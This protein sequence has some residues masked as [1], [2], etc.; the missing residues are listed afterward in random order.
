MARPIRGESSKWEM[1]THKCCTYFKGRI[2][3]INDNDYEGV[4][5]CPF[6]TPSDSWLANLI[7][8]RNQQVAVYNHDNCI[9][10]N[11]MSDSKPLFTLHR[12]PNPEG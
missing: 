8:L 4:I 7:G 9:K 5:D 11:R 3:V 2:W 12:M 1:I 10:V 6:N